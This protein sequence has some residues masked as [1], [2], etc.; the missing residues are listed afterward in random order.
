MPNDI[1]DAICLQTHG[2]LHVITHQDLVGGTLTAKVCQDGPRGALQEVAS[3]TWDSARDAVRSL[4]VRHQEG[5]RVI[6]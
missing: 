3:E 2:G 1:T 6:H 5:P 4:A